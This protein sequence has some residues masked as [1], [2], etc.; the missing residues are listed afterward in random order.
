M[1]C[2]SSSEVASKRFNDGIDGALFHRRQ[3]NIT[4]R[5]L[6]LVTKI[7]NTARSGGAVVVRFLRKDDPTRPHEVYSSLLFRYTGSPTKD[8]MSINGILE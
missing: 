7:P 4:L 8:L 1:I 6:G 2:V 3:S 5:K